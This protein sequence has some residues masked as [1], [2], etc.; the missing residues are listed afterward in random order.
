MTHKEQQEPNI[1][2]AFGADKHYI[3]NVNFQ[4]YLKS[5]N[6]NSNFDKNILVYLGTDV[7]TVPE[8]K[9]ELAQ[10][11]VNSIVKKNKNNCL[12]HGEFLRAEGFQNFL[13]SDIIVFTDG[14]MVL[15][16]SLMPDE[17]ILLRSL[18]DND[19]FV[20]YNVSPQQ[21]LAD[22]SI[23]LVCK[24]S[25]EWMQEFIDTKNLKNIKCYNT[26]VLCMNI[27]TWKK[28][29]F[30]YIQKFDWIDEIFNHYANQQFLISYIIGT[31]GFN[32]IEMG[33]DIHNHNM[34]TPAKGTTK[35]EGIIKYKGKT[36]LFKHK[37]F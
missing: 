9:I 18:Q 22:E 27:K 24:K 19:V 32:I 13:D 10:I 26:G 15:Q 3:S 30:L 34:F 23:K 25:N 20:G 2:L 5:I 11:D 29:C 12:Q 16:R 28:L 36:V 31:E 37:W 6:I 35:E 21:T 7:D 14:D 8:S 17:M 4:N 33:Y 1:I